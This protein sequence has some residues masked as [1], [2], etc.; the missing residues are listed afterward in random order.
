MSLGDMYQATKSYTNGWF[1]TTFTGPGVLLVISALCWAGFEA[2][3]AGSRSGGPLDMLLS[4]VLMLILLV[5]AVPAFI[6][7]LI[8]DLTIGFNNFIFPGMGSTPMEGFAVVGILG[9]AYA[10]S[11]WAFLFLKRAS[12]GL[13]KVF[14]DLNLVEKAASVVALFKDKSVA[15]PGFEDDLPMSNQE[16]EKELERRKLATELEE[17]ITN[18]TVTKARLD[19]RN[20]ATD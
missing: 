14:K 19:A 3:S 6:V 16:K 17:T 13:F 1:L 12:P 9:A 15:R 5:G 20:E 11:P 4:L 18:N 2:V 7:G 10:I 8:I